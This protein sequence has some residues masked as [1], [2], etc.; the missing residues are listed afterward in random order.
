[1]A[2]GFHGFHVI[3]GTILLVVS[4]IRH[5]NY[6]FTKTHHVGFEAAA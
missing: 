1:M 4:L 5:I 2:T 6:H 3:I